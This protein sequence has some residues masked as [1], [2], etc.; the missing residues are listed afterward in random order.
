MD[1]TQKAIRDVYAQLPIE[2]ARMIPAEEVERHPPGT[3]YIVDSGPPL[4]YLLLYDPRRHK[5]KPT[6]QINSS[7]LS[8]VQLA[9]LLGRTSI[10]NAPDIGEVERIIREQAEKEGA[11]IE[12]SLI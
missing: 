4:G 3:I 7:Q 2:P 10:S 9:S 11:E 1:N 8:D 12:F 6:L 5:G